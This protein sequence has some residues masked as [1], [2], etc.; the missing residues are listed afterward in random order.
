MEVGI[1]EVHSCFWVQKKFQAT[2]LRDPVL[3]QQSRKQTIKKNQKQQKHSK[4]NR[5]RI[6]YI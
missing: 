1:W 6:C 5:G 2:G 4:K 3:E